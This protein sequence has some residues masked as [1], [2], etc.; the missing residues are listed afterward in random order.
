[1]ALDVLSDWPTYLVEDLPQRKHFLLLCP[2]V[3]WRT[4]LSEFEPQDSDLLLETVSRIKGAG[5]KSPEQISELLQ[6]P[7]DLV[8]HLLAQLT[9]K[10]T[11]ISTRDA[12]SEDFDQPRLLYSNSPR[13]AWVYRDLSTQEIWRGFGIESPPIPLRRIDLRKAIFEHGTAGRPI[14]SQCLLLPSESLNASTPTDF[15]LRQLASVG[16]PDGYSAHIVGNPEYC[17]TA[18]PVL[19]LENGI[20]VEA[21]RGQIHI[22]LSDYVRRQVGDD[23]VLS[24]WLEH[25]PELDIEPSSSTQIDQAVARLQKLL[26]EVRQTF[27]KATLKQFEEQVDLALRRFIDYYRFVHDTKP[28]RTMTRDIATWADLGK[29]IGLKTEEWSALMR[30]SD[31]SLTGQVALLLLEQVQD[32]QKYDTAVLIKLV[33]CAI[34]LTEEGTFDTSPLKLQSIAKRAIE[35]CNEI[36]ALEENNGEQEL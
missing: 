1:M 24:R 15:E 18:R 32:H 17:L 12:R 23:S 4:V 35:L 36:T 14:K 11:K 30:G 29:R 28:S 13:A 2:S 3:R 19:S 6:I 8:Q 7:K 5:E 33:R 16:S 31:Q 25:L 27:D 22:S 9:T 10:R 34:E 20:S 26:S 21:V